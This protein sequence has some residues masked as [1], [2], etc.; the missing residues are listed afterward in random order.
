MLRIHNKLHNFIKT[1][2]TKSE[3]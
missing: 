1:I 2:Y 3:K